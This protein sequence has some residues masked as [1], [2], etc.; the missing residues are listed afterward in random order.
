MPR[1]PLR[2]SGSFVTCWCLLNVAKVPRIG[3]ALLHDSNYPPGHFER[4]LGAWS[5]LEFELPMDLPAS[6]VSDWT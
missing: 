2:L 4:L 3:G 5:D 6:A 1:V